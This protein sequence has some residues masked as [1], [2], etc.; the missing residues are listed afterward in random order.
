MEGT[1][2]IYA[3]SASRQ[4]INRFAKGEYVNGWGKP[5]QKDKYIEKPFA[6]MVEGFSENDTIEV[7]YTTNFDD[8]KDYVSLST[9]PGGTIAASGNNDNN[10]FVLW[11]YFDNND[12]L[13]EKMGASGI[14][15][16]TY[17]LNDAINEK[18]LKFS[19]ATSGK[20]GVEFLDINDEVRAK[21]W[22]ADSISINSNFEIESNV[23]D[24]S[25]IYPLYFKP[26]THYGSI[27]KLGN[28]S[29]VNNLLRNG[30]LKEYTVDQGMKSESRYFSIPSA[31]PTSAYSDTIKFPNGNIRNQEN[32]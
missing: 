7:N 17:H 11:V 31:G 1:N 15:E 16:E 9:K 30:N 32:K 22:V 8:I 27:K 18:E 21:R 3:D 29:L 6:K 5:K 26:L 13:K 24:E 12:T 4:Q 20:W 2:N 19:Q 28:D 25:G 23:K 10:K 14:F